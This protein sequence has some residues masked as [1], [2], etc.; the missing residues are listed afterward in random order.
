[1]ADDPSASSALD[2]DHL[3]E[4]TDDEVLRNLP[5]EALARLREMRG[6]G[7]SPILF[8]SDLSVA[9]FVLVEDA[10]FEPLGLV[11]GTSIYHIG[12]QWARYFTNQELEV[13]SQAMYHA[14]ELAMRRM[15]AEADQLGADGVV[16][17]RLE[18][19]MHDFGSNTAEFIAIGTAVRSRT[20]GE[21]KTPA[22]RPFTSDLSGQDFW[23]LAE[24]GYRPVALVM[25][26]CVY[27][28]AH[29]SLAQAVGSIA[30]NVELPNFTQAI[31]AARESAMAR[32]QAEA[33]RDEAEGIVGMRIEE[34]NHVWGDHA[35]EF[36]AIG[37]AIKRHGRQAT[38]LRRRFTLSL[39]R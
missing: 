38:K 29:R 39:D 25:G 27:H 35:I 14:R 11:M 2:V 18:I 37:T 32:M 26:N 33:E 36:F 10:G 23:M 21:W 12:F 13:L 5:A 9:E 22:G 4:P 1:M 3:A 8:T 31:Y 16:A 17:V 7:P 19:R 6:A 30:Q 24:T 15:E 34:K 28:V 20:P